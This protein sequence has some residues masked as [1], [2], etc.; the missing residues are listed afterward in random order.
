MPNPFNS[1]QAAQGAIGETEKSVEAVAGT[2][3]VSAITNKFDNHGVESVKVT[4]LKGKV[5]NDALCGVDV[6]AR[7]YSV[8]EPFCSQPI[9]ALFEEYIRHSEGPGAVLCFHD[10]FGN[11]KS[12]TVAA[13]ARG[14]HPQGPDRFLVVSPKHGHQTGSDWLE[15]IKSTL[16]IVDYDGDFAMLLQ[17]ALLNEDITTDDKFRVNVNGDRRHSNT[18]VKGRPLLVLEDLNPEFFSDG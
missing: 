3:P 4:H 9:D 12:T 13:V 17:K 14:R 6:L 16:G 1:P 2:K 18:N 15:G 8:K 5:A 10:V 11:G 7:M